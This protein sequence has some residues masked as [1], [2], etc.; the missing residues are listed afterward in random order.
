MRRFVSRGKGGRVR[1]MGGFEVGRWYHGNELKP[2]IERLHGKKSK[3]REKG[4]I[5]S[6]DGKRCKNVKMCDEVVSR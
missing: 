5:E 2:C 4:G 1:R 6:C 3:G